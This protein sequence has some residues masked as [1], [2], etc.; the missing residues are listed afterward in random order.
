MEDYRPEARIIADGLDR[1]GAHLEAGMRALAEAI[2]SRP[3]PTSS[4]DE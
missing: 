1:F 2:S 3:E 4:E